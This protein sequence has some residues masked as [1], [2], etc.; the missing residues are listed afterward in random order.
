[1]G[2]EVNDHVS[3]QWSSYKQPQGSNLRPQRKQ[4]SWSQTLIT[5]HHLDGL[6]SI[7]SGYKG[8]VP[9]ITVTKEILIKTYHGSYGKKKKREEKNNVNKKRVY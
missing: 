1:M 8:G 2:P 7:F 3:L 9:K 5:G 4:T 6:V